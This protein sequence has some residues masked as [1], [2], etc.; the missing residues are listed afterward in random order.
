MGC[1]ELG[2]TR[3]DIKPSNI[4]ICRNGQVKLCDFGV[5]G[6]LL[7]SKGDAN[8]FIGTSAYMAVRSIQPPSRAQLTFLARTYPRPLVHHHLGRLVPRRNPPRSRP[9]RLPLPRR[10]FRRQRRRP[11]SPHRTPHLHC[12]AAHPRAQ[13]RARGR[14]QVER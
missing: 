1:E 10:R 3:I 8:T 5:S 4:L 12:H 7:G 13:R 6:E 14:R 9:T 11:R 2:L